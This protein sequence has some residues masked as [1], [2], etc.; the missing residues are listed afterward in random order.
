MYLQLPLQQWGARNVYLLV[1]SS[2]NVNIAENPNTVMAKFGHYTL[3][4]ADELRR[5]TA[6]IYV[7]NGQYYTVLRQ[8][9]DKEV[10]PNVKTI[11]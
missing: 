6:L 7:N 11:I 1:L 2:W 3:L 8:T 5:T 10:R 9:P 4:E